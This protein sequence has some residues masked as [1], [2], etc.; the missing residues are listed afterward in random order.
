[1]KKVIIDIETAGR[2]FDSLDGISKDYFLKYAENQEKQSEIK[3][4]G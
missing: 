4:S 3:D 2:D 1:M